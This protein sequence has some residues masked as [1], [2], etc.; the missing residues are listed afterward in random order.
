MIA[1][2]GNIF[3]SKYAHLAEKGMINGVPIKSNGI[4]LFVH[5]NVELMIQNVRGR[6][7]EK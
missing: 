3:Q 1:N 6:V 7:G 2:R 5:N 4:L